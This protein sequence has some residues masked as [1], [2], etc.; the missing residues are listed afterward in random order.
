[1]T[2]A[3]NNNMTSI[4]VSKLLAIVMN[5]LIHMQR[6]QEKEIFVHLLKKK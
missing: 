3:I 2:V 6:Y 4:L 5:L 1:M